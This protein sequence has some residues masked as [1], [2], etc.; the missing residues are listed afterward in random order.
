MALEEADRAALRG[1]LG[2][3]GE[4]DN[5]GPDDGNVDVTHAEIIC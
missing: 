2:G 1:E 4:T 3:D 5:S